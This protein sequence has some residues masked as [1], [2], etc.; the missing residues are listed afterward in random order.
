MDCTCFVVNLHQ[1]TLSWNTSPVCLSPLLKNKTNVGLRQTLRH[2]RSINPNTIN[3]LTKQ[4][5]KLVWV[6]YAVPTW[7]NRFRVISDVSIEGTVKK[8][9]V[10]CWSL[11]AWFCPLSNTAHRYISK[12]CFDYRNITHRQRFLSP[13]N[14]KLTNIVPYLTNVRPRR[15]QRR[16]SDNGYGCDPINFWTHMEYNIQ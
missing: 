4:S 6:I 3:H 5:P 9:S 13:L 14:V 8:M 7:S 10:T 11:D 2:R 12:I 15:L 16:V 1:I